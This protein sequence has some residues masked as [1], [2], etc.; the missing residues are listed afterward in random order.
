[1][2]EA[3]GDL[4][5]GRRR[6]AG[7]VVVTALPVRVGLDRGHLGALGA[8][9]IG[10]RAGPD[11]QYQPGPNLVGVPDEPFQRSGPAHRPADDGGHLG[12]AEGGQCG[13]VG[14]DLVADRDLWKP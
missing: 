6:P 2:R 12:D 14:L 3:P 4:H 5:A 9:L 11:G 1:M 7:V 10:G 8:D 13:P